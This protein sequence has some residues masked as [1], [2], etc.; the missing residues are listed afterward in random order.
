M[1]V[2]VCVCERE[3]EREREMCVCV[4]MCVCACARGRARVKLR[5]CECD[6]YFRRHSLRVYSHCLGS[7]EGLCGFSRRVSVGCIVMQMFSSCI[8]VWL[9]RMCV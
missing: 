5:E 1:C 3:R 8:S 9:V 6:C 7:L 4:C 2:C